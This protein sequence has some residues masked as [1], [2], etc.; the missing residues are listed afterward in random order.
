MNLNRNPYKFEYVG[1]VSNSYVFETV[2][3]VIYQIKFKPTPYLF[4]NYPVLGQESFELVIDVIY[5]PLGKIPSDAFIPSTIAAVCEDFVS[6]RERI[7][8]YI[9]ETADARHLARVRKFDAWFREF[10]DFQFLKLDA[11][12]PDANNVTYYVS[13]IFRSNHPSRHVIIDEFNL[14]AQRYNTDK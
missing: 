11:N 13:L 9:C 4:P 3:E 10:N 5:S 2:N 7:L 1:G 12:F 6:Y 14:L 8:L